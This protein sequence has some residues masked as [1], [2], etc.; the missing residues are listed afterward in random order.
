MRWITLFVTGFLLSGADNNNWPQFRGPNASGVAVS[1]A[2]APFEFGPGK[3]VLWKQALPPGHSSPV[4]WGDRI[5]ITGF[6]KDNS[7]LEILCLAA[8]NG[9]ILWK[10]TV[11]ASQ[12][13][14]V[15]AVSSPVTA[16]PVV[17]GERVYAYFGSYGL[18]AF[19][20]EGKQQ[21]EVTLPMPETRFGSGTSPVLA[22]EL[23]I[24]NRD[25]V[26]NGYLLAVDRKTGKTVWKQPYPGRGSE[27]YSTPVLWR[28]QAIVHRYGSVDAF[29]LKDGKRKWWVRAGT[30][31]TSTVTVDKDTIYAATW[32]P[33]GEAD[34][35]LPLPDFA[36]LLAKYDKDGDGKISADE[37][38]Q[39]L[40]AVSRPDTANIQG[41]TMFVKKFFN[42]IDQNHDGALQKNEWEMFRMGMSMAKSE[43]GLLAIRPSGEGDVTKSVAWR[44][45]TA[46][47]EVPSP[48]VYDGRVY[49]VRNG[50]IVTCVNA[51]S[52]KVLYRTRLGAAGPYY[53]SP[54]VVSGKI[55]IASG[56]GT[57][58]VFAPGDQLEVLARNDLGEEALSRAGP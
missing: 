6:D 19:D 38:P 46:V 57:V 43:H 21:W 9:E 32:N 56:D 30:S 18:I 39:D 45:N 42:Q 55:Y 2:A 16:T 37:F 22:G 11:T 3:R 52:G 28:D 23:L 5:F 36:S 17:D 20:F 48:L 8:R 25:E 29:D 13:E 4:L 40:A 26:S 1:E 49:M 31:G 34:Q 41:A 15:Q 47:P 54:I 35:V 44:E 58:V 14:K 12:V 50:G 10:R 51:Q 27:S 53:S 33:L 7:R 24:L